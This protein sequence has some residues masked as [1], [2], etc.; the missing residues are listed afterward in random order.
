MKVRGRLCGPW[1]EE[2]TFSF[3]LKS[4]LLMVA[5]YLFLTNMSRTLDRLSV[6]AFTMSLDVSVSV[7]L[8]RD[9][10]SFPFN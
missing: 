2:D 4:R 3:I 9:V 5:S 7:C 6:S 1:E 8:L 10:H